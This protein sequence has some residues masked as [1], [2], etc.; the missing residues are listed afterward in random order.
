[1]LSLKENSLTEL[2]DGVFDGLTAL[3][4]LLLDSNDLTGLPDGVFDGLTALENL[5]WIPTI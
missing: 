1:M 5:F 2:P 3:E 4:N